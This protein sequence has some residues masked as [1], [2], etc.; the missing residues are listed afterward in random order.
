MFI[1]GASLD[2]VHCASVELRG[3]KADWNLIQE[4]MSVNAV[5]WYVVQLIVFSPCFVL[6]DH[7]VGNEVFVNQYAVVNSCMF[8]F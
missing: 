8:S 2:C 6:L 7:V 3:P 1:S 5:P 4:Q